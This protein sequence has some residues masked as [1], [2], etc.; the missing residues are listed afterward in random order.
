MAGY[1][2]SN[3]EN[4]APFADLTVTGATAA[5]TTMGTNEASA[6]HAIG[7]DAGNNRL[8]I[9]TTASGVVASSDGAVLTMAA[10]DANIAGMSVTLS[11]ASSSDASV[12][13]IVG[14]TA[15]VP[16]LW[17]ASGGNRP[18]LRISSRRM[19]MAMFLMQRAKHRLSG[20]PS[21]YS[22]TTGTNADGFSSCVLVY[23]QFRPFG[24]HP[25]HGLN[26]T[27]GDSSLGPNPYTT[28]SD[29]TKT[30]TAVNERPSRWT[31]PWQPTS[32]PTRPPPSR[33][34]SQL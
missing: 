15:P 21:T 1:T 8:R 3:L 24:D 25:N 32:P 19:Q 2:A 11:T 26:I 22:A 20:T 18:R 27:Q 28:V 17:F 5:T 14:D 10:E 23:L 29:Q 31:V 12:T 34:P 6:I 13:F 16:T 7:L 30:V 4:N 9:A 33:R